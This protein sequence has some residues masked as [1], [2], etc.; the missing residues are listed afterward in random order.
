MA[1]FGFLLAA[2]VF[3]LF[4]ATL[5]FCAATLVAMACAAMACSAIFLGWLP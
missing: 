3:G 5:L 2:M 4:D 1:M